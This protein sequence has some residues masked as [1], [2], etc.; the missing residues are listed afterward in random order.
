MKKNTH[1][2]TSESVS[3][4][5]PDK[6]ADQI[7]DA[8]LDAY[9]AKDPRA[10]VAIECLI[11]TQRLLIAGEVTSP[12]KVNAI[13][14]AKHVL[15]QIGYND[16]SVGFDWKNAQIED[17]IHQ[18]SPEILQSVVDGGAGDQGIMFGH[19]CSDTP[20]FMPLAISLSHRIVKKLHDLRTEGSIPWLRP[21]A[22][23]QVTI[24]YQD[25]VP[26]SVD[27][28]V[29]STQHD[30]TISQE[31]LRKT[32]IEQVLEPILN[33]WISVKTPEY[34]INPSGS[35]IIGGPHGDTGL[36]G[37]KIVVDT[38]GGSCPHGGGAFSGKDPSKVDRSA[39]YAAR[40]IAKH[41][42]ATGL[43]AKCTVQLSYAIGI[44]EPT[45]VYID[46][47]GTER[48]DL[49]KLESLV[50]N[51]FPLKP[52]EII[53]ELSLKQPIYLLTASYGHFGNEN[54]PWEQLDSSKIK[55]LK[56]LKFP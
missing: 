42:V 4:G 16:I 28:V 19:A 7:S 53:E 48:C 56:Q 51:V 35:F 38:Y 40:F 17:V 6:I 15:D 1:Q 14:I 12:E 25:G 22:K 41:L 34:I 26:I 50:R 54:Y 37:R 30:E 5:H 24:T 11:T 21:D 3:A 31:K 23:S 45:S 39:A 46:A 55:A 2:F 10:K 33:Q 47:F 29:V 27:K 9:L 8:I 32:I 49:E 43:V 18:Q 20:E 52:N 36:T 44:A 13:E